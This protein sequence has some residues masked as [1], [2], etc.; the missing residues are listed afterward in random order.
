[1]NNPNHILE[2]EALF[3]GLLPEDRD[4]LR[5]SGRE[6]TYEKGWPVVHQGD[7][8]DAFFYIL[9]GSAEISV[10]VQDQK[11]ILCRMGPGQFFGELALLTGGPRSA[12]VIALEPSR[13]SVLS[14]QAFLECLK[15][16]PS[17]AM[18]MIPQLVYL[19][20]DLTEKHA[21]NALDTY[22]RIRY[23]LNRL[24]QPRDG[25][26]VIEGQWTHADF[27]RLANCTRESVTQKFQE[28][29][30]GGWIRVETRPRRRIL[31]LRELPDRF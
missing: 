29:R 13:F 24:A 15:S 23:F 16:R 30:K 20:R 8:A 11:T 27:G 9:E 21:V 18:A 5:K 1:M 2:M 22:G 10:Q 31:L 14:K 6:K 4:L 26:R 7:D 19:V 12:S 28:L 3:H 25:Y 17:L